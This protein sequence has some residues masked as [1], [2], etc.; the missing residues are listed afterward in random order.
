MS[1]KYKFGITLIT[2]MHSEVE[3]D[4]GVLFPY[5]FTHGDFMRQDETPGTEGFATFCTWI[6][7]L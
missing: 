7:P 6:N 1:P 5:N 2:F 3:L 4:K